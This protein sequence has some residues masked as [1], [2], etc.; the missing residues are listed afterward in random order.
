MMIFNVTRVPFLVEENSST[1]VPTSSY[2][3][4]SVV[5]L[6]YVCMAGG[7]ESVRSVMGLAYVSMAG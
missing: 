6:P 7:R 2:D 3:N 1:A 4:G 5:G